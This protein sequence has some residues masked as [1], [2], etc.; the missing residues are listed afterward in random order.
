MFDTVRLKVRPVAIDSGTL[1]QLTGKAVT[2][3][4]KETGALNTSYTFHDKQI[5]YM[6]YI[7]SSQT[8]HIQVSIPKFLYGDNVTILE[9]EDIPL[10]FDRLQ[11]RIQQLFYIH[12][13]HFEW[14][15]SRCD[16]CWNFQVGKNVGDY[17]RLLSKQQ[18]AY[19]NTTMYNQDQTVKYWNK[20]SGIMF[21]DKHKQVTKAKESSDII[22]RA[23]GI[24]RL[25]VNPSDSDMK[26]YAPTRK[27]IELIAKPFFNYMT[28]KVL[29]QIEYP[30]EASNIG[31]SWLMENKGNISKIETMLGFQM[32]QHM[33]DESTLR[34]I[35]KPSTYAIR[36]S[37]AKKMTI[38]KGN[39]LSPLA[40]NS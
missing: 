31:L 4:S 3:L 11:E 17:V 1:N 29:G 6:K 19:K 14:T 32:L 12:I 10:F 34:Q 28:D 5:P 25:E 38:P 13:P 39:C 22:E 9:E 21:Y 15:V 16:V 35:Y 2:F 18:L 33:F 36:K 37:T 40:I 24:L 27:A 20:S 7:E 8:L 30:A 23:K 26:K